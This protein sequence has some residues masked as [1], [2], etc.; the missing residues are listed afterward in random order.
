MPKEKT[1]ADRLREGMYLLGQL[2]KGGVRT[3]ALSFLDLKQK[4][5]TWIESGEEWQGT[6]PFPEYGREGILHLPKFTN[7]VAGMH[8]NVVRE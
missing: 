3:N 7:K 6:I 2:Q 5:S 1:K 4:I 8:F